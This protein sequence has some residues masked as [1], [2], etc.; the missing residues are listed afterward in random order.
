MAPRCATAI[1]LLAALA[2]ALPASAL[3]LDS[4]KR[5]GLIGEM[6]SGYIGA[7]RPNPPP[8]VAALV[9]EVN[10]KR[11]AAYREI[12]SR[13]GTAVETVAGL[14]AQKLIDRGSPGD[15]IGDNGKWY[16]KK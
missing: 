14:A 15:W 2:L 11:E 3:D 12:A 6:T 10:A 16:Q 7:V 9:A 5:Q 13:N 8:E 4:A 1:A